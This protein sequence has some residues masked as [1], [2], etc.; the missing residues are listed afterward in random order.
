V[1]AVQLTA[2]Y[3]EFCL[4]DLDQAAVGPLGIM[5]SAIS[6]K[7]RVGPG[8]RQKRVYGDRSVVLFR[9]INSVS[10]AA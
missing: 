7:V 10:S 8:G 4:L 5:K 3:F 1:S 9:N 6:L 2:F